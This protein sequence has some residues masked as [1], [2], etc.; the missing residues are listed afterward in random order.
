MNVSNDGRF[1][2]TGSADKTV[3]IWDT[4]SEPDPQ[5][6]VLRGHQQPIQD[7]LF[8]PDDSYIV[9]VDT[10]GHVILWCRGGS[11]TKLLYSTREPLFLLSKLND[12][13]THGMQGFF[14]CPKSG[15]DT[16]AVMCWTM[17]AGKITLAAHGS[18]SSFDDESATMIDYANDSEPGSIILILQCAS[19]NRLWAQWKRA[20]DPPSTAPVELTFALETG[21]QC[22]TQPRPDHELNFYCRRSVDDQWILDTDGQ[23][24][25]WLPH[26]RRGWGMW[27]QNRLILAGVSGLLTVLDFE[28]VHGVVLDHALV[29]SFPDQSKLQ[30]QAGNEEVDNDP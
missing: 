8:L 13:Y 7:V 12:P 5:V 21:P 11:D 10:A 20:F 3:R 27:D 9:S 23:K 6:Q 24:I 2:V 28:G 18:L 30:V 15:S 29:P 25:L 1:I 4:M 14:S 26:A 16:T 17:H 19:G 22:Q